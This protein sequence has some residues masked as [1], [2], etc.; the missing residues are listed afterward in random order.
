MKYKYGYHTKQN[1]KAFGEIDASSKSDVYA[2]LKPLGIKPY[3]VELAPGFLNRIKAINKVWY[4][5]GGLFVALSIA[6]VV[7]VANWGVIHK[8]PE[9][10]MVRHQIYGD[11][12]IMSSLAMNDYADVFAYPGERLLARYAQPG[13]IPSDTTID[14]RHFTD[15]MLSHEIVVLE[16]DSREV[17]EL[18]RIVMWMKEELWQYVNSGATKADYARRLGDRLQQEVSIRETARRNLESTQDHEVW[19]DTNAKLRRLGLK[20]FA[21]PKEAIDDGE[22]IW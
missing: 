10:S 19:D 15:D 7:I 3:Y 5:V 9:A 8:A 6:I 14:W 18:K 12:A 4:I 11:P 16:S 2:Q 1:E 13:E 20:T 22:K 21:R 17:N